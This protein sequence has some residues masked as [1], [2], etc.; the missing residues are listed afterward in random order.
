V[1]KFGYEDLA[2]T[3]QDLYLSGRKNEAQAAVPDELVDAVALVGPKERIR[4]QLARWKA[5]PIKTMLIGTSQP[6]A[7]RTLAEL[8][9]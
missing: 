5:S 4:D 2:T 7:L 8:C 9:M 1:R 3:L 6:E